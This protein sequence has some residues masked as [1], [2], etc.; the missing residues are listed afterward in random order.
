MAKNTINKYVW[1]ADTI[2]RA[3]KISFEEI[4]RRWLDSDM[5]DG[6]ALSIRTFHKWRV[7][8]EEMFGLVI[9]NE[10]G[11]QYRYYI[12]NSE[13]LKDGSMRSWLFNTLTVSNLMMESASIKD[14]ILF[15]EIPD[16]EQYLPTILEALK[17]NTVLEMTYQSYWRDEANTFTVEPYC[18]KAFKQRWYLVGRS[19]YYNKI[20]IY[21]LDRVHQ[22]ELTA[23]HFEYPEDFKAEDYFD[24]CFGIIADVNCKVETVKLKVSAGQANYLRSLTLHQSQKEIERN[25]EYS[26]FTVRLRPTFDFRQEILSQGCDIE[27]LEPKW[28][29]DEVAEISKHM[30]NKYKEDK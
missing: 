13:D 16:G 17:K 20:M 26:I 10:N 21:A 22:L 27:V 12:E 7:A 23:L 25:D 30:W 11:G 6:E 3:K 9:E 1:L 4:N 5:S 15:E 18:L 19:P 28:F 8:I 29:R 24:E 2:Y 14:K